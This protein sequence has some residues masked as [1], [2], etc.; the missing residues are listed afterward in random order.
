MDMVWFEVVRL[1][2]E[3]RGGVLGL[4]WGGFCCVRPMLM[5]IDQ[6]GGWVCRIACVVAGSVIVG[7]LGCETRPAARV[8]YQSG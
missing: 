6:Q 3:E 1:D 2:G 7:L 4:S 8:P 5:L